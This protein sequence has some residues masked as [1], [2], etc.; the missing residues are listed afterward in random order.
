MY[1][2]V[3]VPLDGSKLAEITLPHVEEIARKFEVPEV[4]LVSV[5]EEIK[6]DIPKVL[7]AEE[8]SARDFH[9]AP[10]KQ[11]PL[12]LGAVHMG[13]TGVVF[14]AHWSQFKPM[15][16]RMGKMAKTAGNYLLKISEQ[17]SAKGINTNITVLTG[18]PAEA[19]LR[20]AKDEGADLIVMA[21]RGKSGFNRW[22]MGNIADKVL[23]ASEIPVVLIK[24]GPGFKETK[25][26]RRG[27]P[28]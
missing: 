25:P 1:K 17:F 12:P 4:Y 22:D 20:F 15:P 16:E 13:Q 10:V 27:K 9:P 2:K 24:P 8:N 19:I 7:A 6:G 21:S 26:K 3:V 28:N 14:S 11:E 23:R 18:N 5:T